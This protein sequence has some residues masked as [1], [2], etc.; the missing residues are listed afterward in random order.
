[1]GNAIFGSDN[2]IETVKNTKYLLD[3]TLEKELLLESDSFGI[4]EDWIKNRKSI[5]SRYS[6]VKDL[7]EQK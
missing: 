4:K 2:I 3:S 7:W 6:V 1:M 5:L